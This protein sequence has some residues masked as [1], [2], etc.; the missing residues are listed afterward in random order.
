VAARP[1]V[2]HHF[3][4]IV[5][6]RVRIRWCAESRGSV[7]AVQRRGIPDAYPLPAPAGEDPFVH[8]ILCDEQ[9]GYAPQA[10][11]VA[12]PAHVGLQVAVHSDL[13]VVRRRAHLGDSYPRRGAGRLFSLRPGA[14]GR[15]Y[16]NYRFTGRLPSHRGH[17]WYEQW[18]ISVA[19]VDS[20]APD[21]FAGGPDAIVDARVRLYGGRRLPVNR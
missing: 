13:A 15:Y 20:W 16:S 8:D 3:H 19:H 18:T 6:Q 10:T 11:A 9:A 4:V 12:D 1:P 2:G 14:T 5:V 17:W 7:A 21:L